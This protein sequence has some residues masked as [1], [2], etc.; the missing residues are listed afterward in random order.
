MILT[1]SSVQGAEQAHAWI[2]RH[3]T[4]RPHPPFVRP[5]NWT[6]IIAGTTTFL[7][8]V[9]FVSVAWPYLLPIIQ[10]RNIW[11]AISLVAILLFISG[12]MYNQIR[13]V[14]YVAGDGKGGI[15][16]FA[17]GFSS[18]FG[19]ESQIIACICKALFLRSLVPASANRSRRSVVVCQRCAGREGPAHG[20]PKDAA[21]CCLY[22]GRHYH[23]HVQFP[24]EHFPDQERWIPLLAASFLIDRHCL[25]R[26]LAAGKAGDGAEDSMAFMYYQMT[27]MRFMSGLSTHCENNGLISWLQSFM[28]WLGAARRNAEEECFAEPR[29][30]DTLEASQTNILAMRLEVMDA[31]TDFKKGQDQNH[32]RDHEHDATDKQSILAKSA[33]GAKFLIV[34][35]IGSRALTFAANQVLLRFISPDLLG[36]STQLD[37][38]ANS[39][40]FFA[41]EALRVAI[42]RQTDSP[43]RRR[44]GSQGAEGPR[45]GDAPGKTQALVNLAYISICLG[46]VFAAGLAWAYMRSLRSSPLVRDTPCFSAALQLYAVAAVVELLAE[47]C[48]VV[49]QQRSEYRIRAV[50]ESVGALLRCLATC[51]SIILA[52]RR[53]VDM[54]AM[55]FAFGQWAYALSVLCVYLWKVSAISSTDTFSLLP[56]PLTM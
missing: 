19:L 48:F 54:G 18:Q 32:D 55:P 3:L 17:G 22:L 36:I 26:E 44:S 25:R 16:Y 56:R 2:S 51:A 53:G 52:A 14:P 39:V 6:R 21:A 8:T 27:G 12:N 35:Q 23:G 24:A 30:Q 41:R 33:H 50:A 20:Q 34:L 29:Q 13:K 45:E 15:S 4:D 5:I 7:G 10:N 43:R 28:P 1:C 11:A 47:P 37:I 9:V 49:V 31:T 40:L 46:V 42:Q 38:Y